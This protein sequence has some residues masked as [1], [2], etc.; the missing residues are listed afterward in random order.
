[1]NTLP[2]GDSVFSDSKSHYEILDG[3]RGVAAIMV[4][5]F[6]ILEIFSGGIH[7]KQIINH[8]YLAVDFF[9][10]L[11]GFVVGH[12]YDDRWNKMTIGGFFKRRLI[13]LHPM[14]VIGMIVG[15]ICFYFS[16]SPLLF[17]TI[18]Q[19][20]I[21]KLL[22]VMVIG[23]TLIPVPASLEI[24][25]WGEMHPLNGPAWTLFF[26]Y[27]GNLLYALVLRKLSTKILAILVFIAGCALIHLAVTSPNGDIIGG[28]SIE[29]A[30]LRIGFTRFLYPFL[31]GLLLSR[32]F[33]PGLI[34]NSFIWCSLF[35]ILILSF[36][37]IGGNNNLWLNGLYDSLS[38]II[39][40]P[41]I[42]CIAASGQVKGKNSQ[43][44]CKFLGNISYP[45]YIVHYPLIYIF[46]AWVVDNK[47]SLSSA[48]PIGLVV[49]LGAIT[50]AYASFK[51]Y[52]LPVRKWL[53]QNFMR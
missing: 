26:E 19:I 27:V 22:L 17:P 10:V 25:G 53:S 50:L 32:I 2:S 48:W 34:K 24:R 6:H 41:L 3:L 18:S 38:I 46:S 39:L 15:A 49:L 45:I 40:F 44:F 30:Q 1:M 31:V 16:A 36:P 28:W 11:S 29:L 21:W 8:G 52:D 9:F 14:I 51:L 5:L 12:A 23:F 20:P 37:R 47:I 33:K 13:R 4:V 7:A 42:V 43:A 35:I